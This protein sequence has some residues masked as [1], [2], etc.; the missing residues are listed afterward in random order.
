M[1]IVLS[2]AIC[3]SVRSCSLGAPLRRRF[4]VFELT[5][6]L[7]LLRGLFFQVASL[8]VRYCCLKE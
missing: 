3:G 8:Q 6:L 4:L 5:P 1:W 7:K 2:I